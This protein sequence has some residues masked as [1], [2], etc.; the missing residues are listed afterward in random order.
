MSNIDILKSYDIKLFESQAVFT[1]QMEVK[2]S[3]QLYR[4][5][6]GFFKRK[7]GFNQPSS[8]GVLF[9]SLGLPYEMKRNALCG[10]RIRPS[11]CPY[12]TKYKWLICG[13]FMKFGVGILYNELYS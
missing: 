8:F 9:V 2:P 5:A 11:F 1:K 10:D 7:F 4:R 13:I 12:M 6:Y 3:Q